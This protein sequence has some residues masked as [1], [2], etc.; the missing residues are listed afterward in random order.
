LGSRKA[1]CVVGDPV[2]GKK[3]FLRRNDFGYTVGGGQERQALFLLVAGV[4]PRAARSGSAGLD[5]DL[6]AEQGGDFSDLAAARIAA[7]AD[8]TI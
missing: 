4:E 2:C 1:S 3:N 8:P 7:G 5:P 6:P